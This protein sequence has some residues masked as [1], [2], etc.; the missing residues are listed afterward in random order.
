MLKRLFG[1]LGGGAAQASPAQSTTVQSA[2]APATAD[3]AARVDALYAEAAQAWQ[4]DDHATAAAR[5]S[6]AI[7]LDATLPALHYLQ[8]CALFALGRNDEAAQ[9]LDRCLA[10]QPS[11]PLVLNA[12]THAALARARGDIRRGIAPP[13]EPRYAGPP[14]KV[15]V[16]ICSITPEKFARVSANY[17]SLLQEVPHEIIGIHDA[18]SMCEGYNRGLRQATGDLLVFSHDDIEILAPDFADR[19]RNRLRQYALVGVAGTTQLAGRGWVY[20]RW[21]HIHGQVGMPPDS[22]GGIA[23]T[24]FHMRGEATAGAQALDGLLLACRREVALDL[25]FDEATFDG[26][27]LYDFDFSFRAWRA[28]MA[29]AVCHDFLVVHAS[30]GSFGA[31][32][33]RYAQRFIA[34]HRDA[35]G[36]VESLGEAEPPQLASVL[37]QSVPE[38]RLFTG[39]MCARR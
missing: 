36:E 31:D 29:T 34:K 16:I 25:Q 33:L 30:K 14:Q 38:W 21:P 11:Y 22:G 13:D 17:R 12:E 20:A 37:L 5:T 7:A 28:G 27:H 4:Q 24:A 9:A 1:K 35:L 26:W 15:S 39:H 32:W 6:A 8:G 18:R 2:N 3:I 23:V 19:L 10:L